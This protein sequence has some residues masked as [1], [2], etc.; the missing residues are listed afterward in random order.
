MTTSFQK[1]PFVRN[2]PNFGTFSRRQE[3]N[4][5]LDKLLQFKYQI[6]KQTCLIE[7][8]SFRELDISDDENFH[9]ALTKST[10]RFE[11]VQK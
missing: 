10:R 3:S 1:R 6:S 7:V 5:L 8:E 11:F 9:P 2:A 4:Y